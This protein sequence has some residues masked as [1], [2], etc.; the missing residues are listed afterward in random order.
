LAV[1]V[2]LDDGGIDHG[3]FHVQFSRQGIEN[4]LENIS[5]SPVPEPAIGCAPVAEHRG[6]VAPW[7]ARPDKPQHRLHP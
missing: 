4:P 1:P 6:Q 3:I 2:N 5:L 7:T